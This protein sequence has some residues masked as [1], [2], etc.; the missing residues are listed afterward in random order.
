VR[1]QHHALV[2]LGQGKTQNPLYR[3]LRGAQVRSGQVRI[4]SPPPG[5]D[6]RTVQLLASRYT[7]YAIPALRRIKYWEQTRLRRWARRRSNPK[8]QDMY[9]WRW[10]SSRNEAAQQRTLIRLGRNMLN[11]SKERERGL[12]LEKNTLNGTSHACSFNPA[13]VPCGLCD[14]SPLWLTFLFETVTNTGITF[15]VFFRKAFL[16]MSHA[17][18]SFCVFPFISYLCLFPLGDK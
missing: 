6:V 4:I 9:T 5:F 3:R 11:K 8:V 13:L 10:Q 12:V 16:T 7:D 17:F 15:Y 14:S 18:A 1:G 2:A